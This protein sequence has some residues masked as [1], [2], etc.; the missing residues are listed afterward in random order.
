MFYY[1]F[2]F[3]KL[4]V[5]FINCIL[6]YYITSVGSKYSEILKVQYILKP[7]L[8]LLVISYLECMPYYGLFSRDL[9]ILDLQWKSPF[10][11]LLAL[12]LCS[13]AHYDITMCHGI[14]RD[15]LLWHNNG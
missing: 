14:A 6:T 7:L 15:A 4:Y 3:Y 13:M 11:S 9:P 10:C 1:H 8:A 12:L 2:I 5:N